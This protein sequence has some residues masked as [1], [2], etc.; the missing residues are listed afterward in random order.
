MD[1]AK[2]DRLIALAEQVAEALPGAWDVKPF[3]ED[4]GR[5]GAWLTDPDNKAM[6]TIGETQSR[7]DGRLDVNTDYPRDS[8]GNSAYEKRPKI[9][10]S[11]SKSGTQIAKDIER[12]LLPEYLPLL[13]KVL[14]R[15]RAADE[16]EDKTTSL[17]KQIANIVQVKH[18]PKKTTVS[19]YHSPYKLF[20]NTMSEASVLDGQEVELTLRLDTETTFK[21]LNQLIHGRFESPDLDDLNVDD[22]WRH[23]K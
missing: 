5:I 18:D 12:R 21:V 4:W 8:Q 13:E 14:V 3:P 23:K 6:L 10:V 11:D 16:F 20:Q 9:T 19:F 1:F 7:H 15:Y 2:R 22:G 17:A